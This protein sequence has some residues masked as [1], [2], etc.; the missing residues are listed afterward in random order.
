MMCHVMCM[1]VSVDVLCCVHG[2]HVVV[3]HVHV[4]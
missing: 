1:D 2:C 4:D 3:I